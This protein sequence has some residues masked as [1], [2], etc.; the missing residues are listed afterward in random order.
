[1]DCC[2]DKGGPLTRVCDLEGVL[3]W[4]SYQSLALNQ[5]LMQH[6]ACCEHNN[7][8]VL[9][10]VCCLFFVFYVCMLCI[11]GGGMMWAFYL[12]CFRRW[13]CKLIYGGFCFS[14]HFVGVWLQLVCWIMEGWGVAN[15]W[16]MTLL[17]QGGLVFKRTEEELN[18]LKFFCFYGS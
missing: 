3:K 12:S 15:I 6:S 14:W 13:T 2:L 18:I 9:G 17:Q 10:I 4:Q 11:H 5:W 7:H 1:M 8:M 16:K